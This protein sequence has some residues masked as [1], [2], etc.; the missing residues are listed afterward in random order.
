MP[1]RA[2]SNVK[3][4]DKRSATH[5]RL[6]SESE[7]D[8][9]V[10]DKERRREEGWQEATTTELLLSYE[11]SGR[12][13]LVKVRVRTAIATNPLTVNAT[14]LATLYFVQQQ[15]RPLAFWVGSQ[16]HCAIVCGKGRAAY[17]S[18]CWFVVVG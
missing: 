10:V 14:T 18:T 4:L 9:N 5:F 16:Q 1:K 8:I 17:G 11:S 12:R 3:A 2:D 15:Q 13:F 6:S 7:S